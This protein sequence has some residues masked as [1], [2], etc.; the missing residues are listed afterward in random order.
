MGIRSSRGG[1]NVA[2]C[3]F[4]ASK[5][6]QQSSRG[7]YDPV[8]ESRRIAIIGHGQKQSVMKERNDSNA[9][10]EAGR[11]DRLKHD[12]SHTHQQSPIESKRV[13][14]LQ[15]SDATAEYDLNADGLSP[16]CCATGRSAASQR[17]PCV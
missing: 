12:H 7:R 1:V 6:M 3:M 8:D 16:A 11:N 2:A 10:A 14:R 9:L 5:Q 15:R 17:Q 4:Q 13:T